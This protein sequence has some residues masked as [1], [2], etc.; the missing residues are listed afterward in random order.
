MRNHQPKLEVVQADITTLKV[1]AIVNAANTALLPGG[2]VCGAIHAAAGPELAEASAAEGPCV[3]GDA[4]IT[5]GFALPA[6]HV[7]HAVGPVWHGGGQDEEALLA[8]LAEAGSAAEAN[9]YDRQLKALWSKSGS[10]AMD[11]LLKRGRDAMEVEDMRGAIEHL[12]ALTDH[13]P[14]FAEGFHARAS[15]YFH[16]DLYGPAMLD[17]ERALTLNPRNYN[18]IFGLG[19]ILET[20][21]DTQKAMAAYSHAL[22]LHPHHEDATEAVKRLEP[23]VKGQSL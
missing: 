3:T 16:A 2:G 14:D 4:K 19:A 17:L 10:A 11:L 1:D 20:F 12:T 7:I 9:R 15:A 21:G 8:A 6:R 22:R 23:K 18:A 13:A 5:P